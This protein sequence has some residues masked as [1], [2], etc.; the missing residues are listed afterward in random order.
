MGYTHIDESER[1]RIER[2]REGG[3][4]VREIARMIGRSPSSVSEELGRNSVRKKYS[5]Q[6]AD[7]NAL[8]RR[9]QSKLQCLKV[10]MDPELKKYVTENIENDQSPEGISGRLKKVETYMQYASTKAIYKF[11]HSVHGRKIEKHL[12]SK[13]VKRR[14]GPKR[15]ARK[16]SIDGR[17][18]IDKRPQ[19]VEK[20]KE[21]GHFE[22]DFIESGRDGKG[23]L[24]VL[25]ERKTRYPFLVYTENKTTTYINT[26]VAK[27]FHGVPIKS[28]TLDNDISFQKHEELS[29]LVDAVVFFCHAYHSWEKGTVENRN[30]AVRRYAPKKTDLSSLSSER[31]KEIEII[32]RTRYMKVLNFKTPEEVWNTEIEKEEKRA[33]K[34]RE[35]ATVIA[36]SASIIQKIG[37]SA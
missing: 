10:A 34:R 16:T 15:G 23:S 37:C 20:R 7:L 32:L 28:L 35:R 29:E 12:Y 6:R 3:K 33:E 14:G 17:T 2:A 4:G 13:A 36:L 8:L 21:F 1:R 11:V 31:F 27:T 9:K 19:S 18:M 24:L 26:L 25:V 22:G 30:R 5:R